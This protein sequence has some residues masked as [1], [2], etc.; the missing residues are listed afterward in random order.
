MLA[1]S[2]LR[3]GAM[4]GESKKDT[5]MGRHIAQAWVKNGRQL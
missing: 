3:H 4:P 1:A 5:G 2:G